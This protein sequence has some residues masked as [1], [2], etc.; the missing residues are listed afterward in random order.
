M[1]IARDIHI[2]RPVDEVFDYVA[3][4]ANDPAWLRAKR[5]HATRP[6][7]RVEPAPGGARITLRDDAATD[8]LDR[9]LNTLKRLLE[10]DNENC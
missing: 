8:T 10:H 6:A 2:A 1:R 3:N 4:P 7:Y 9:E 5:R